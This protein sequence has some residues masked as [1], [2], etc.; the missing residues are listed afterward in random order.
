MMEHQICLKFHRSTQI[1]TSDTHTNGS[2]DEKWWIIPKPASVEC[3]I[4]AC[5][6]HSMT[7]WR[8]STTNY[9][10]IYFIKMDDHQ[11]YGHFKIYHIQYIE[12]NQKISTKFQPNISSAAD[13][14]CRSGR[15]LTK[16]HQICE[17]SYISIPMNQRESYSHSMV[18]ANSISVMCAQIVVVILF[19][20]NH[21][22]TSPIRIEST[23]RLKFNT[24]NQK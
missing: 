22:T 20:S 7:K 2:F 15:N 4:F 16:I 23:E 14:A 24:E 10:R 12:P 19:F 13:N 11:K 5:Y 18:Y 1:R 21:Q 6:F 8:R 17:L 9:F 3:L